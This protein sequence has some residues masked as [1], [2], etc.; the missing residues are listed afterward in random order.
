MSKWKR[1]TE[2]RGQKLQM[3]A[4]RTNNTEL[5]ANSLVLAWK[6]GIEEA[7]TGHKTGELG[8]VRCGKVLYR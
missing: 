2:G 8:R 5:A 6:L 3:W 7:V 1:G 4:E